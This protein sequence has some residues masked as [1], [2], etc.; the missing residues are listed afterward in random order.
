MKHLF[1]FLLIASSATSFAQGNLQFNQVVNVSGVTPGG[2]I[3]TT[4][5]VPAGKVWKITSSSWMNSSGSYESDHLCI[6]P[7]RLSGYYNGYTLSTYPIW[8]AEG[9][10]DVKYCGTATAA[11]RRYAIS[12]IEFNVVP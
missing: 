3:F 6:G 12:A 1:T 4:V 2:N 11:S 10:Y 8:L 5:T 9:D 7:H